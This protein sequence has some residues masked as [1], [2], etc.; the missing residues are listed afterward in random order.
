MRDETREPTKRE[1]RQQKRAL[2]QAGS[3]RRRRLL[4]QALREDPEDAGSSEADFGR[5][6]TAPLNGMD[7]DATRR[8]PRPSNEDG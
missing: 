6:R 1:L 4:K 7:R 2:K 8:R 3:Q 5:Y